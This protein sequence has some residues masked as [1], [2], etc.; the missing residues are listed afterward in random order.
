M[1]YRKPRRLRLHCIPAGKRLI[2][3]RRK[4][5]EN[6]LPCFASINARRAPSIVGKRLA[7]RANYPIV[8]AEMTRCGFA[9]DSK[10]A[11]G[12]T[13]TETLLES[14]DQLGALYFG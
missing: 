11:G 13:N 1:T 3:D 9:I 7:A 4:T 12:R 14:T 6:V 5:L 8:P 10:E 2:R